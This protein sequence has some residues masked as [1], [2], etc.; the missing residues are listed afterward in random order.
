MRVLFKYELVCKYRIRAEEHKRN[1]INDPGNNVSYTGEGAK[2]AYYERND[3]PS[4]VVA[5]ES[6][7][8]ADYNSADSLK[9]N[10][11]KERELIVGCR[12]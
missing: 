6:V 3:I 10:A 8:S 1:K 11:E 12:E 4:F 2:Y 9:D 5:D 7:Y